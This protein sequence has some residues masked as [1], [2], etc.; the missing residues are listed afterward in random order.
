MKNTE[1]DG[2][3]FR[4]YDFWDEE[5]Y[6]E[7]S[8]WNAHNV[9]RLFMIRYQENYNYLFRETPQHCG[10]MPYNCNNLAYELSNLR[11]KHYG[12]SRLQDREEKFERYMKLDPE[13][14]FGILAQYY[15]IL[16]K[17]PNLK[18]WEE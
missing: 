17:N 12:W 14:K 9:Y 13:G 3:M 10:R 1:V 15:S 11:L 18:K 7:D 16:D 5:H 4:L 2:Y 6:R 8:L